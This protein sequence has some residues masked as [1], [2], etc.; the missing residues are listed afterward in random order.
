MGLVN[1][2]DIKIDQMW[3]NVRNPKIPE[4]RALTAHVVTS[5]G[6][7]SS[8]DEALGSYADAR[9]AELAGL[10]LPDVELSRL[11]TLNHFFNYL[12]FLDDVID[13][14][15]Q[16]SWDSSSLSGYLFRHLETARRGAWAV[17]PEDP[18]GRY[19]LFVREQVSSLGG[20]RG[21]NRFV[22]H[23]T[24]YF[25]KGI[26]VGSQNCAQA[27]V[28]T[29]ESYLHQRNF[30][31]SMFAC[32][33]LTH[34]ANGAVA[35]ESDVPCHQLRE[36][37]RRSQIITS[38]VTSLTNDLFSYDKEITGRPNPNNIVRVLMAHE[39][40]GWV[41][42]LQRTIAMVNLDL[43]EFETIEAEVQ[44]WSGPGSGAVRRRLAGERAWMG[45][46]FVWSLESGRYASETSAFRELRRPR[47]RV[48]LATSARSVVLRKLE[49]ELPV[50]RAA[51]QEG[52]HAIVTLDGARQSA[53]NGPA[54]VV[55][56]AS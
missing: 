46:N 39:R 54:A 9:Y 56:V 12:F 1:L 55:R 17:D 18:L 29:L 25:F 40:I 35:D 37:L 2:S 4:L 6:L 23:L 28:P 48:E 41:D 3:A 34:L 51:G 50:G 36:R 20:E 19:L 42:A 16:P 22:D 8:S 13:E 33:F 38:R 32:L 15:D 52:H 27:K 53:A 43:A 21:I 44:R 49:G 31:S 45:A 30:D 24:D 47:G 26:L 10:I 5:L 14:C 11:A 7:M